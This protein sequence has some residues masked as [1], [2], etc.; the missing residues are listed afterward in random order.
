MYIKDVIDHAY[1]DYKGTFYKGLSL[2]LIMLEICNSNAVIR[3]EDH[4]EES[5]H[6]LTISDHNKTAYDLN[7][8]Q[9]ELLDAANAL[10]HSDE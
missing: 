3:S 8:P 1:A 4:P 7:E 9:E 6:D 2:M 5:T 10:Y